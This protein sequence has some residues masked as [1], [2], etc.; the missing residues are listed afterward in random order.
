[1]AE[2]KAHACSL[3][4]PSTREMFE[5]LGTTTPTTDKHKGFNLQRI[6]YGQYYSCKEH[7]I[8]AKC[9]CGKVRIYCTANKNQFWKPE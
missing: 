2:T 1:M 5:Y 9:I 4:G 7:I 6:H 3:R 8:N